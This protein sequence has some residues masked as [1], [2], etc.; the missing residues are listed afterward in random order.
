MSGHLFVFTNRRRD[1]I[2]VLYWDRDGLAIWMERLEPGRLRWPAS[3][4]GRVEW[5]PPSTP[6]STS[7]ATAGGDATRPRRQHELPRILANA[8]LCF[9]IYWGMGRDDPSPAADIEGAHALIAELERIV[10]DQGRLIARLQLQ[11]EQLLRQKY[12]KKREAVDPGQLLL[13]APDA[14]SPA[15]PGP[16]PSRIRRSPATSA[17]SRCR[18]ACR[19]G[20]LSTTSPPRIGPAPSAGVSVG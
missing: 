15:A 10:R 19:A 9:L 18:P 14:V 13:F 1:R 20:G 6:G 12:G 5:P 8:L 3:G 4:A 16:T 11:L 7:P 2:K 17:A